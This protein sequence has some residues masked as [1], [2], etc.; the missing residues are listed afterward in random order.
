MILRYEPYYTRMKCGHTISEKE[1][2]KKLL[3]EA[4]KKLL[5][6]RWE[7]ANAY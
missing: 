7:E 2:E 6:E 4:K 3:A 5:N 1:A